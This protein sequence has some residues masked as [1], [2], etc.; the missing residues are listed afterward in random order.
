MT[1]N[2]YQFVHPYHGRRK[3]EEEGDKASPLDFENFSKKGRFLRFEWEKTNFT[4][5]GPSPRKFLE[6]S[7]VP[8]LGKN[9]SD[10]RDPYQTNS[11]FQV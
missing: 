9:H 7:L 1:G 3:G 4:T 10:A 8:P 6:K 2:K 5:F 11:V